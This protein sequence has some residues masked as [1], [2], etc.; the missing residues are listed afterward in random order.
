MPLAFTQEDSLVYIAVN[1]FVAK[2][3]AHCS[4]VLVVTELIVSG[5]HCSRRSAGHGGLVNT[6]RNGNISLIF[7]ATHLNTTSTLKLI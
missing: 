4:R 3:S 2:E 7:T 1:D 5:T 6:R